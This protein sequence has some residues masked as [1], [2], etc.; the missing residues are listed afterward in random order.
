MTKRVPLKIP[1]KGHEL[2]RSSGLTF[3]GPFPSALTR[4]GVHSMKMNRENEAA[5]IVMVCILLALLVVTGSVLSGC[6]TVRGIIDGVDSAGHG[7]IK[8]MRGAVNGVANA[9]RKD[10]DSE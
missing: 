9:D 2:D 6:G 7:V 10:D 4:V 5:W 8:D 3:A 1:S